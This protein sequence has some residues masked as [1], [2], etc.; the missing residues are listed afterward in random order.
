MWLDLDLFLIVHLSAPINPLIEVLSLILPP[1]L[2][3][4]VPLFAPL[5]ASPSCPPLRTLHQHKASL[6]RQEIIQ[7]EIQNHRDKIAKK[8]SEQEDKL[9]ELETAQIGDVDG[10]V[11]A[12]D[13]AAG[14]SEALKASSTAPVV[15]AVDPVKIETVWKS[16][17]SEKEDGSNCNSDSEG[18]SLDLDTSSVGPDDDDKYGEEEKDAYGSDLNQMF[19]Q[20]TAESVAMSLQLNVNCFIDGFECDA[21]PAVALKDEELARNL[22]SFL[23]K[24]VTVSITE[25]VTHTPTMWTRTSNLNSS[26]STP[27]LT[28][29]PVINTLIHSLPLEP[30]PSPQGP[31]G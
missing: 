13:I 20:I 29:L 23:Y 11:T 7:K 2:P 5:T 14:D 21:D 28:A 15:G 25:Q 19:S 9:K 10:A 16:V 30:S 26:Y 31:C 1:L 22:A 24:Q 12:G 4:P 27:V 18:D 3:P 8:D 6:L 17:D